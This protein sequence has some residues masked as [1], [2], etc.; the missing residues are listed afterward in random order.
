MKKLIFIFLFF[1]IGCCGQMMINPY[2][3]KTPGAI[4]IMF[5]EN[6]TNLSLWSTTGAGAAWSVT[7][8][9]LTSAGATPGPGTFVNYIQYIA[10]PNSVEDFTISVDFQITVAGFGI[11]LSA[12][13]LLTTDATDRSFI[14]QFVGNGASSGK[15][16]IW[17]CAEGTTTPYVQQG[18]LSGAITWAVND[19]QTLTFTKAW[20]QYTVTILNHA[21]SQTQSTSVTIPSD[22][23]GNPKGANPAFQFGI[24]WFG[25]TFKINSV[26]AP[27]STNSKNCY[28]LWIGD[29]RTYGCAAS[30]KG[31]RFQNVVYAS[32]P[33][34]FQTNS[35]SSDRTA[36]YT[37][38]STWITTYKANYVIIAVGRNDVAFGVAE[39]TIEANIATIY[40]NVLAYGGYPIILLFPSDTGATMTTFNNAMKSIYPA[41]NIIDLSGNT[42]SYSADGVHFSNTG[43]ASIAADIIAL[44]P[45]LKN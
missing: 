29:S 19:N 24:H 21:N 5:S 22:A 11:G 40:N 31:Q 4:G 10:L 37:G 34:N 27:S 7:G 30:T 8:N 45:D 9:V 20:N 44:R 43:M 16:A 32:S 17:A 26:F 12:Q 41:N 23:T 38:Q 14:G 18:S 3:K 36:Q 25:G 2:A 28:S 13:E 35:G 42:Y 1:S 39:A 15:C 33:E 6:W